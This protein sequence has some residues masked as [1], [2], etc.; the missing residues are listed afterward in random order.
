MQP[1]SGFSRSPRRN[2]RPLSAVLL[3]ACLALALPAQETT[4]K[5]F[6]LPKSRAAA[7][8]V[9]GRLSNQELIDAPRGE[10]V[11][12]ALLQ[13][14]GLEGKYRVEAIRGIAKIRG[15]DPL[16]ELA[17][18][19]RELDAKGEGSEAVI[20]DL[21]HLLLQ[22]KA[23][24]LSAG[25]APL[26][27]LAQEAQLPLTRETA[28]AALLTAD[29]AGDQTW[30]AAAANPT[31]LAE[32]LGAVTLV[33]DA[34]LRAGYYPRVEPLLHQADPPE[35]RRAAIRA[36]TAIPGHEPETFATLAGMLQAGTERAAAVAGLQRLPRS[37]WPKENQEAL[38]TSLVAYLQSLPVESRTEPEA[39]LAFQLASDLAASLPAEKAGRFAKTLRGLGVSVFVIRAVPEQMRYDKSLIVVEAGKPVTLTLMNEDAM[40]HNLVVVAPGALEEIGTAAEKLAP[41]PDGEGRLYLPKSDKVLYATKL[42]ESGQQAK[43]SFTAP[44]APGEYPFVCTF[45]GHWRRMT[46]ILAVAN[47][48]EAYVLAHP[49]AGPPKMTEWKI[50]DL[51]AEIAKVDATRD[52]YRGKEFFGKLACVTCHKLGPEGVSYGPELTDVFH[53]YQDSSTEVLRQILE[54]SLVI[55]NRYRAFDFELNDGDEVAGMVVSEAPDA[56][57]IQTGPAPTLIQTLKKAD[58]KA[59]KQR[60]TSLM[61]SGLLNALSPEEIYDLLAFLKAGGA[62]A[63]H[64]HS[65]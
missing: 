2:T 37:A 31:H 54:P 27:K 59:Q 23:E 19:L 8:Y 36:V 48:V 22:T 38:V 17:A 60:A 57:T 18:G 61:P 58:I 6:F 21:A 16:A 35:V 43:L 9:L 4:N 24:A 10:F 40:P 65:H 42:V 49:P 13:R 34:G 26:E 7:A 64:H 52:L 62:V 28:Y 46:G 25:R 33:R 50:A 53:R 29:G 44:E 55:S 41:E 14:K 56:L 32:L 63:E 39:A 20:H 5:T 12:A 47:D 15:T 45:P 1:T 11:Y 3:A 51:S 30:K